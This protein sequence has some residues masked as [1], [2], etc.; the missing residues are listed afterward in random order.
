MSP[1]QIKIA[2]VLLAFIAYSGIGGWMLYTRGKDDQKNWQTQ[3]DLLQAQRDLKEAQDLTKKA[4]QAGKDFEDAKPQ[5]ATQVRWRT[6]TIVVP[7]DA[8]PLLPIWFVRMFDRLASEDPSADPYPGEPAGGSSRTRLS[9]A[10]PVLESWVTKYETCRTAIKQ[11]RE[12]EPV[13]PLP[14]QDERGFLNKLN[15]FD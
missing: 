13:L 14:P 9:G 15:P 10:R 5:I 6:N 7:P 11:I 1:T 3:Q 8:D 12:L 2:I 4:N